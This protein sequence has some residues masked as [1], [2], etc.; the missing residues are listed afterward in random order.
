MSS[1]FVAGKKWARRVLPERMARG[2]Q[3]LDALKTDSMRKLVVSIVVDTLILVLLLRTVPGL[4]VS[5]VTRHGAWSKQ[6]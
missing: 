5:A 3:V 2:A 6:V 4:D 1:G